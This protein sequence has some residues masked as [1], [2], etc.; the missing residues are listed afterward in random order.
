[1]FANQLPATDA[2]PIDLNGLDQPGQSVQRPAEIILPE[3]A[4]IASTPAVIAQTPAPVLRCQACGQ[5]L[6]QPTVT[7]SVTVDQQPVI[8]PVVDATSPLM[9]EWN[10]CERNDLP[11]RTHHK[12]PH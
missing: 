10:N 11:P 4:V 12:S 7:D 3:P 6:P 1:M 9:A 2:A 8:V 5:V